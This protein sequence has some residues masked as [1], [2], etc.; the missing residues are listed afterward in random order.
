MRKHRIT[1]SDAATL[2]TGV[3][4][5]WRPELGELAD[6]IGQFRTAAFTSVPR[7]SAALQAHLDFDP[8]SAALTVEYQA[9]MVT[10]GRELTSASKAPLHRKRNS[11]LGWLAGL[12]AIAKIA[13]GST[14]ALAAVTGA[15]AAG[16][17]PGVTQ[18]AFDTVI[19][20]VTSHAEEPMPVPAETPSS[21]PSGHPEADI[22][23]TAHP[24]N[25]GKQVSELA[26]DPNKVGSEFGKTVSG[27][28]HDKG[29]NGAGSDG[30][31]E[32]K[33]THGHSTDGDTT[34]KPNEHGS[35]GG[36]HHK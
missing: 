7:P 11:I 33:A 12:G 8:A 29:K 26:K 18:V 2:V 30:S 13:L 36:S 25:F 27:A 20:D 21:G 5:E 4:P 23:S 17:L 16:V 6:A 32:G 31:K 10:K 3:P 28:A 19:S 22:A 1:G 35:H 24:D 9:A 15:G 34:T 14:V